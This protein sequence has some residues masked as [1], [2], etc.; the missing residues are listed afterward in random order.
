LV[1]GKVAPGKKNF[2]VI[3]ASLVSEKQ[4]FRR[5]NQAVSGTGEKRKTQRFFEV[6]NQSTDTGLRNM[7]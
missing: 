4:S 7:Q 3:T 2:P 6:G 5:E 1:K